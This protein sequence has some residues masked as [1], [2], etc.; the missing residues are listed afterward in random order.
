MLDDHGT[1]LAH[2]LVANQHQTRRL[3]WFWQRVS[4]RN[5][6]EAATHAKVDVQHHCG[7]AFPK[8]VE[9]ILAMHLNTAQWLLIDGLSTCM[10]SGTYLATP[11]LIYLVLYCQDATI[12]AQLL[13]GIPLEVEW[14]PL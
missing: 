9:K 13:W 10:A 11:Y 7:I 12:L 2:D 8:E 4:A 14:L 5:S 1:E 6:L 3:P